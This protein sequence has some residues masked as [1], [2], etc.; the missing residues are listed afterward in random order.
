MDRVETARAIEAIGGVAVVRAKDPATVGPIARALLDGGISAIE[1]TMTMPGAIDIIRATDAEFGDSIMLGVGSVTDP[2]T[3]ALA[4]EAGA[5]YV[6]SPVMRPEI[7]VRAH[8]MGAATVAGAFTPTE[9]L[10][11]HEV[12]SEFVKIFPADALGMSFIKG[13][14]APM[15]YLKLVP[16]GGVTPENAGDWIRAGC[17]GVG[18]GSAL[19]DKTVIAAGDWAV[20]TERARVMR[21]S[22]DDARNGV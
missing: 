1:V 10:D 7:I 5:R 20:L 11:A 22:I 13:V 3:A 2:D 16:T 21:A 14:L 12:G 6:V 8:E 4:I 9:A 15:P 18:I 17:A 19:L